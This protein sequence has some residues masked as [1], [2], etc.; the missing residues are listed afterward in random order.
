MR[1]WAGWAFAGWW[2]A[3][4][5]ACTAPSGAE[6]V[7]V[8][9]LPPVA[10]PVDEPIQPLPDRVEVDAAKAALG[11]L[12]FDEKWLAKDGSMSC[13]TCHPLSRAAADGLVRSPA[14]G[15]GLTGAN[16][17]TLFNVGFNFRFSWSGQQRTLEE[18]VEAALKRSMG[19]GADAAAATLAQDPRWQARFKD[20]FGEP[21]TGAGV[22]AA[23]AEFQRTLVTPNAPLDRWLRGDATALTAEQQEGYALFKDLGCASCHQGRNVGG[24]MFQRMGV[25][26]DYFSARGG[27]PLASDQGR[28]QETRQEEDRHVFRVPSLRNVERTA[29]YLHDGTATTLED[30]VHVMA[31]HQLGRTLTPQQV[32]LLVAFLRSLTAPDPVLAHAG[33]TP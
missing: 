21:P 32:K 11:G 30:A 17:P 29:P 5:L 28:Y 33:G 2:G 23:L 10:A 19:Q 24:N 27:P 31:A 9:T 1:R 22:R 26:V 3:C 4:A 16:T 6:P 18:Q 7:A 25:M 20:V 8:P 15:G 14:V 13:A 12:L